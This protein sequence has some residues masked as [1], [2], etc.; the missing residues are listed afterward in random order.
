MIEMSE[1]SKDKRNLICGIIS[2]IGLVL[3]VIGT[4]VVILPLILVGGLIGG[5]EGLMFA[6]LLPV[7]AIVIQ[8]IIIRMMFSA[9]KNKGYTNPKTGQEVPI[10][11]ATL[12][13]S[14]IS[15]VLLLI[16]A[17]MSG[18]FIYA[19]IFGVLLLAGPVITIVAG[20]IY[21]EY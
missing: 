2:I 11:K 6:I 20:I 17:A 15:L 4:I 9:Y 16:V 10:R 19:P 18:V 12:I 7:A 14:I 13:T 5:F 8:I 21:Q 3:I 1:E